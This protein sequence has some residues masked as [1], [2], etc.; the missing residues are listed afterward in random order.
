MWN[1]EGFRVVDMLPRGA[2]FDT[3]YCS[4]GILSEILRACPVRSNRQLVVHIDS[5]MLH[6]SKQTREFME[7]NNPRVA[8]H[9]PFSPDLAP[10]DFFLFDCIKGKLQGSEFTEADGLLAEIWEIL[11]GISG[12]V[13]K[14]V[15]VQWE[16]RQISPTYGVDGRAWSV[17]C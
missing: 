17:W 1:I 7:R 14:A 15:F 2:A 11:N 10:S 16:E 5:S 3:D 8:P 9:P 13:L 4:E 12:K 6:T